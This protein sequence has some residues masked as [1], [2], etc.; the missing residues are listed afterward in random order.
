V[1]YGPGIG[2]SIYGCAVALSPDY[3]AALIDLRVAELRLLAAQ[4]AVEFWRARPTLIMS[5]QRYLPL[6][7]SDSSG[8]PMPS[9][10]SSANFCP[11]VVG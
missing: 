7:R 2:L 5:G 3:V 9:D 8:L 1:D 6:V 4:T 11:A 10:S